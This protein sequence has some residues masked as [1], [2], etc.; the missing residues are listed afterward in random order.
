MTNNKPNPAEQNKPS[1]GQDDHQGGAHKHSEE[2]DHDGNDGEDDEEGHDHGTASSGWKAH[3]PLLASLMILVI[4]LTLEFGFSYVPAFPPGFIIFMAA[5]L[6]AGYN[7]L[8][9]AF[10]KAKHFDFFN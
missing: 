5:Y 8:K 4:M 6:L 7:V 2:D 10:V 1:N 3:I 9:L